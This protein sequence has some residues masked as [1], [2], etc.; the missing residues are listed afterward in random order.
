MSAYVSQLKQNRGFLRV[1]LCWFQFSIHWREGAVSG[2]VQHFL[3]WLRMRRAECNIHFRTWSYP[4]I[5]FFPSCTFCLYIHARQARNP[6]VA[7][8]PQQHYLF[9]F[10]ARLQTH[11][12]ICATRSRSTNSLRPGRAMI[13]SPGVEG[14]V[15]LF[16][17]SWLEIILRRSC[18]FWRRECVR[19]LPLS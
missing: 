4:Y 16:W 12:Q 18:A 15:P 1:A 5:F 8:T 3:A 10:H 11:G 17:H 7:R 9:F 19:F 2:H 14:H 13:F 6:V